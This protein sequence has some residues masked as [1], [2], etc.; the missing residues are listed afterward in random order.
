MILRI[1]ARLDAPVGTGDRET[2]ATVT[3]FSPASPISL[4]YSEARTAPPLWSI[5]TCRNWLRTLSWTLL[6]VGVCCTIYL[7]DRGGLGAAP[8]PVDYRMFKNPT[9]IPM[10]IFGLPH[11]IIAV[12]FV[13][14]SRRIRQ[15]SNQLILVGLLAVGTAF[16]VLFYR[17]GAH[18]NPFLMFLFYFY[19]LIHGFRDDAFFYKSYGDMPRDGIEVHQRIMAVLQ[20]LIIGL[21]MSLF[22]PV[23]T[24][25]SDRNYRLA[26]PILQ[27]FFPS[28]WPFVARLASMF[29][30]MLAIALWALGRIARRFPDGLAGLWRVHRPILAIQIASLAIVL[31]ALIGGPW[32]FNIVVLMH[33]VGWYFFA[34]FLIDRHPPKEPARG[35]WPWMRTTRPGFMTLHLGLAA[36]VT[37]LI[38]VDVYGFGKA[39]WLDVIVGSKSF[40]Y[41]TIMH[42]T[43]SFLPR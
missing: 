34:L 21:L 13:L 33:F 35:I 8:R 28:T 20:L 1:R 17:M 26:D 5:V 18:L 19:F 31:L 40:Y 6:A 36:L 27:N 15:R 16:C 22:W 30:P 43:L 7:I 32:T 4:H 24:V 39:S 25:V 3:P 2:S 12:L 23:L 29:V 41:W 38:A 10:R 37:V 11:F 42:V 9:E 14:S